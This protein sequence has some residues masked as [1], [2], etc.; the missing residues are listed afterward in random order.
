MT[1]HHRV[2]QLLD[3]LLTFF[4]KL[5]S[6]DVYI[7]LKYRIWFKRTINLTSPQGFN[8]KLNWLKLNN[9]NPLFA[10]MADKYWV[11]A[12]VSEKI[13][14]E[15]VVPC[16]GY[17]KSVKDI[18]FDQ[19]PEKTFVKSTHDS[20]GGILVDKGAGIDYKAISRR[21]NDKTLKR[22]NWYW[23]L[24]EWPYKNIEPGIIAE[25]YL[26][27][28]TG[29][30]LHDYKFYCFNGVPKYMYITNKGRHIYE[31]FYDMDFRPVDISHNFDRVQPE[32]DKPDNFEKMKELAAILSK[33]HPFVRIDFFNV[34]GKLYF[35]EFTFYDWGGMKPLNEKWEKELG[36]LIDLDIVGSYA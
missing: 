8:E 26:D 7:R 2:R 3:I 4:S 29:R 28:G 12:Y 18:D 22:K 33:G 36:S 13:G 19:L 15:Y 9:R 1:M 14:E 20:G 35:G 16:Y 30:E 32:Y 6:D 23:H 10:M 25:R 11:K 24:R 5:F 27:E 31:N 17:W 34:N 21:F